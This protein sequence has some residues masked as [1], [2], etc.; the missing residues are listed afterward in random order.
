MS[1]CSQKLSFL[2]G[3]RSNIMKRISKKRVMRSTR[4]KYSKRKVSQ[5]RRRRRKRLSRR[6]RMRGGSGFTGSVLDEAAHFSSKM[7]GNDNFGDTLPMKHD[8]A[9][10]YGKGNEYLV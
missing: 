3:G 1:N 6:K 9:G 5:K 10:G 8:A 7:S 4:N 2:S